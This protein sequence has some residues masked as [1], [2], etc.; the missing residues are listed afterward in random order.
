MYGVVLCRLVAGVRS[1]ATLFINLYY[2]YNIIYALHITN[3]SVAMADM[4][5]VQK[6]VAKAEAAKK[7][8]EAAAKKKAAK[9][10]AAE[11][12]RKKK[13]EVRV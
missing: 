4:H 1:L 9:K 2:I 7:K 11:A 3:E 8:K 12:K 13:Q 5:F 10:A 6:K